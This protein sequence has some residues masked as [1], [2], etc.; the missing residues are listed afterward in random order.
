MEGLPTELLYEILIRIPYM[1]LIMLPRVSQL[2]RV[3]IYE[4]ILQRDP[5]SIIYLDI[6]KHRCF[7]MKYKVEGPQKEKAVIH[8]YDIRMSRGLLDALEGALR[9]YPLGQ[10]RIMV[11][12]EGRVRIWISGD[13]LVIRGGSDVMTV[14]NRYNILQTI[15][16]LRD[17]VSIYKKKILERYVLTP[18]YNIYLKI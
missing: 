2:W 15:K 12:Y 3:V 5:L 18:T 8:N 7:V 10:R 16:L 6:H 9:D 1:E 11:G 4:M 14:R 17:F 13:E